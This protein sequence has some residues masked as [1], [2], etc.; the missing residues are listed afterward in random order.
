MPFKRLSQ[1]LLQLYVAA[2]AT[3]TPAE[4]LARLATSRCERIRIR[5]AENNSTPPDVLMKLAEDASPEVRVAVATNR[6]APLAAVEKVSRDEDVT[7]RHLMAQS[8]NVPVSVLES[9]S[10]DENA[11][12]RIEASKTL[13]ILR[14]WTKKE[15]ADAR[16]QIKYDQGALLRAAS[17]YLGRAKIFHAKMPLRTMPVFKSVRT[18][19]SSKLVASQN[20]NNNHHRCA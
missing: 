4:Q 14:T 8:I 2:G 9:L 7:V 17:R 20:S 5:V 16:A 6:Y 15:L 18:L 3:T 1:R 12:V 10:D 11:W 19:V 13:E